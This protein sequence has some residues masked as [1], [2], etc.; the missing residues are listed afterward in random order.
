MVKQAQKPGLSVNVKPKAGMSKKLRKVA[1]E[2]ARSWQLYI[3]LLVPV[4]YLLIFKYLPMYGVQIAFR[5]FNPAL[6]FSASPWVGMKHFINFFNSQQ[7][8]RLVSNT[9]ILGFFTMLFSFPCPI[10]LGISINEARNKA[11]GKTA[12]MITYAPY[13][14]STVILVSMLMQFLAVRGGLFNSM[15]ALLGMP[16]INLMADPKMFRVLYILSGIW[17]GTGYGAVIYIAALS[18]VNPELYEAAEIDGATILKKIINIDLPS[19]MPVAIMLLIM[20][21]GSIINVG[22]EKVLLMQNQ[23]NMATSDVISTYVYRIGITSAQYSYSS[24]IGLFNSVVSI[25]LLLVVNWLSR[26]FGETSLF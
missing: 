6:G 15:R 10:I 4:V 1:G 23:L 8:V 17:Q 12:Q 19:I 9:L 5:E 22:Y 11:F 13:F 25:A 7:F 2:V 21:C 24:A 18:S 14:I 16:P 20:N 26:R 3:L